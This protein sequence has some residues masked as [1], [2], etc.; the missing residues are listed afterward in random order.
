MSDTGLSAGEPASFGVSRR[1]EAGAAVLAVTGALDM[2]TSDEFADRL[3]GVLSERPAALIVD[4]SDLDF[5]ASA[6]MAALV[7]G[8][9]IAEAADIEL[10]VV[11]DGPATS[12]PLV[13]T[14]LTELIAVYPTLA[15]A[16]TGLVA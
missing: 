8:K 12:R 7:E 10:V 16:V 5:L 6:G 13:I 15:D 11:A 14:G 2:V 3:T 1:D 4:L 9:R